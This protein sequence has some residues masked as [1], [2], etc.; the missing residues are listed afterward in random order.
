MELLGSISPLALVEVS[1]TAT[2]MVGLIKPVMSTIYFRAP[3]LCPSV[4]LIPGCMYLVIL[5]EKSLSPVQVT[6][7]PLLVTFAV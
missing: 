6:E 1:R 2:D 4:P 5:I 7:G 3:T